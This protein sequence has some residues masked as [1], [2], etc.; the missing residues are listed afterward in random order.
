MCVLQEGE[1]GGVLRR[2]FYPRSKTGI[3]DQSKRGS[4]I[5]S[6][7]PEKDAAKLNQSNSSSVLSH[8]FL[9]RKIQKE[10]AEACISPSAVHWSGG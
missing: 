8:D 9:L 6:F 3:T 10:F 2:D 4:V 1:P 7:G 5:E